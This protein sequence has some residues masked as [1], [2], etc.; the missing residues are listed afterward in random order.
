MRTHPKFQSLV[1]D[2]QTAD[3]MDVM[4]GLAL[5]YQEMFDRRTSPWEMHMWDQDD[6][7]NFKVDLEKVDRLYHIK[8][9]DDELEQRNFELVVRLEHEP[10]TWIFVEL[11]A[12]CDF[13]GFE[14]RGG[15]EIYLSFD[16]KVFLKSVLNWDYN[17]QS[18]WRSMMDDGY[19][20]GEPLEHELLPVCLWRS[21]PMLKFLCHMALYS[22][23]E[24]LN[25]D[26]LALPKSL[27]NSITEFN[28]MRETRHHHDECTDQ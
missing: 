27:V 7:Q 15:G 17:I 5:S 24:Q 10:K 28:R 4:I 19:Q 16:P 22:H 6:L 26:M 3:E 9:E 21:V 23:H 25:L 1:R 13:T 14:C 8:F 20:V 12:G 11:V 2:V 18:I